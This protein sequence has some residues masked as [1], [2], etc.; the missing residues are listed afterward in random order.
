MNAI[1]HQYLYLDRAPRPLNSWCLTV[2]FD[3]TDPLAIRDKREVA[4]PYTELYQ[5]ASTDL[6]EL[7]SIQWSSDLHAT[8]IEIEKVGKS[9]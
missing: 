1:I 2:H 6:L 8:P 9:C 4:L 3:I 7:S 5:S